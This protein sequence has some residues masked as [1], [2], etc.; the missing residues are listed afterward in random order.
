MLYIKFTI[1][2]PEKMTAFS[3]LYEHMRAVRTPGY[4]EKEATIDWHT[5][6]DAEI[7]DFMDE[8]TPKIALFH[9]LF[10]AYAQQ[11]LSGYFSYENNK[12][13]LVREDLLP[14]FN[15]LEYGFEVD[16]YPL[17]WLSSHEVLLKFATGNYPYG[18]MDRFLMTLKAFELRPV[19]CFDGFEVYQFL[20]TTD[21]E[22]D[23]LVLKEKTTEYI[24]SFKSK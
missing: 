7:D 3:A 12:S 20:W 16:L 13:R 23:A 22:H 14:F 4:Q 5:A 8:D 24:A 15:Y 6:T 2:Y 11:F 9:Q 17:E 1:T 19:E 18:G 10:P 21:Y